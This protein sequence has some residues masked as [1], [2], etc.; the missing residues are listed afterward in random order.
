MDYDQLYHH[1]IK[2][3]KWGVRR[4]QKKD[5]SLTSSGRKRYGNGPDDN[6]DAKSRPEKPKVFSSKKSVKE[7]TD[8]ELNAAVNRL[9][10]EQQYIQLS[11]EKVSLGKKFVNSLQNDVVIP[12]AKEASK[13]IVKSYI[14]KEAKK[15]LG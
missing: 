8:A 11:P 12:A 6:S 5:G 14:E 10:L 1:G 2:G 7:M 4:F 15:R 13:N 3:M 9:R